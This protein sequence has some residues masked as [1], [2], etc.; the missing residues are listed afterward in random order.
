LSWKGATQQLLA[1][2]SAARHSYQPSAGIRQRQCR[3][4]PR[5]IGFDAASSDRAL[6][7]EAGGFGCFHHA[8]MKPQRASVSSVSLMFLSNLII[9]LIKAGARLGQILESIWP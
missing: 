2:C 6:K 5:H 1:Y 7:H 8:G 3:Q 9:E 4:A